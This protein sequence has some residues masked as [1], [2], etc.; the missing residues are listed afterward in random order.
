MRRVVNV[1]GASGV[2]YAVTRRTTTWTSGTPEG[3]K[4]TKARL[5]LHFDINKTLIVSDPVGGKDTPGMV[6]SLISEVT[7]GKVDPK[8][9][10]WTCVSKRPSPVSPHPSDPSVMT[11]GEYLENVKLKRVEV[12]KVMG[13]KEAAPIKNENAAK[14]A[15]TTKLKTHFTEPGQLGEQFR[16]DFHNVMSHL[17]LPPEAK[18]VSDP[19]FFH[20]GRCFVL[21]SFFHFLLHLQKEQR[22]FSL[23]FRTFGTE[24]E[25]VASELNMFC[26]GKHPL[27]PHARADGTNGTLDLRIDLTRQV[28]AF[29]LNSEEKRLYLHTLTPNDPKS[30]VQCISG[31]PEI[32]RFLNRVDNSTW[33]LRDCYPFWAANHESDT[34]GKVIFVEPDNR[35]VHPIFFDDNIERDRAHIVNVLTGDGAQPLPFKQTKGKYLVKAEPYLAITDDHYFI[36]ALA[37]CEEARNKKRTWWKLW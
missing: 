25:K 24:I 23:T 13:E 11:F 35:D 30:D 1:F 6:N 12:P 14:K 18:A 34:S 7:W 20:D 2:L 28:G 31:W 22:N 9:G 3:K 17:E 27:F 29:E 36:K 26:E 4:D 16:A 33:A 21:P 15:Q 19:H 8:T 37:E 5:Q 10:E 32:S